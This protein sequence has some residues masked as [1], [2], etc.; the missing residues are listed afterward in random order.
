MTASRKAAGRIIGKRKAVGASVAVA[1]AALLLATELPQGLS[2]AV[3]GSVALAELAARSP[4]ARIGGVALKAK[5]PRLAPVAAAPG[6]PG[7]AVASVLS[8]AAG[9]EGPLA[10][11][12]PVGPGGFPNEFFAPPVSDVASPGTPAGPGTAPPIDFGS[13]PVPPPGG[14]LIIVPGGPGGTT[15]TEPPVVVPPG[16]PIIPPIPEPSTWLMLIAGFGAIGSAMRR[17]RRVRFA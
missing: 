6:A 14:G 15:P 9:P 8:A 7:T 10:A 5:T 11:T 2:S 1:G 16:P 13:V 3:G 12:G 4:G 17:T